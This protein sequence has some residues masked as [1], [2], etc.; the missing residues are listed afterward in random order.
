ME[1]SK[2]MLEG[3]LCGVFIHLAVGV[4]TEVGY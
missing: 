4:K 2:I 1:K 3:Q